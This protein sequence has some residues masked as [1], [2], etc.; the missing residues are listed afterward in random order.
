MLNRAQLSYHL[1]F[2]SNQHT[3]RLSFLSF[4][5]LTPAFAAASAGFS[6]EGRV[7]GPGPPKTSADGG[8]PRP[9]EGK[10]DPCV[11]AARAQRPPPART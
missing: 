10:P 4:F 8:R 11:G 7:R 3:L 1:F 6:A 2:L 5:F 9:R